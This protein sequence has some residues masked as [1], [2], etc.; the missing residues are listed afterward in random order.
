MECRLRYSVHVLSQPTWPRAGARSHDF[1]VAIA[2]VHPP[3]SSPRDP[4]SI[5]RPGNA[6]LSPFWQIGRPHERTEIENSY[7]TVVYIFVESRWRECVQK[8]P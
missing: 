2:F 4:S 6:E 8:V 1:V 3:S 7:S 5:P